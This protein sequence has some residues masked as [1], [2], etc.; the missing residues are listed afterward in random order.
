MR[1]KIAAESR[2]SNYN[3]VSKVKKKK[4]L[5][6][7]LATILVNKTERENDEN[8]MFSKISFGEYIAQSATNEK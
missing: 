1:T 3:I 8:H 6:L 2:S 4:K 5:K 7:P